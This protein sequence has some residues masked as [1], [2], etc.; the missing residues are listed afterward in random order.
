MLHDPDPG[1]GLTWRR[2][3]DSWSYSSPLEQ[4][5]HDNVHERE[6]GAVPMVG[7]SLYELRHVE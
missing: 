4:I 7:F 2:T 1:D 3:P 5:D 6:S